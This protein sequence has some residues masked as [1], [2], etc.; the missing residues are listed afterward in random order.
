MQLYKTTHQHQ[1]D[2][3]NF[4]RTGDY[5]PIPGVKEKNVTKYRELIY[6]VVDDSLQAA[7]PLTKNLLE[8]QEWDKMVHDFFSSHRCQSP[9]VWQMPKELYEYVKETDYY[10]H[11]KYPFIIDLLIFEWMEVDVYMMED[12]ESNPFITV[13]NY[14]ISGLVLNPEIKILSLDYPVHLK[15]AS[16]IT[17]DDSGQY[18][19]CIHRDPDSGRVHF[20]DIQYPH[21]EV[22]EK[23]SENEQSYQTLLKIFAKYASPEIAGHALN[24]FI[25]ASLDSRLILG[26]A[27]TNQN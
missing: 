18:Y 16:L 20:T 12:V 11:E 9:Q 3:A 24:N 25:E 8:Q 22:I 6:N 21:L 5:T 19:V 15:N 10:L 14:K 7:F 23:L 13:G 27:I 17:G 26:Y 4:C 2:L 1:R